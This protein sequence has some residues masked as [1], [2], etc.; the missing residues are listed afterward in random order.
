METQK[1]KLM[2]NFE[3]SEVRHVFDKMR[4]QCCRVI[5]NSI[6]EDLSKMHRDGVVRQSEVVLRDVY[7]GVVMDLRSWVVKSQHNDTVTLRVT[8]PNTWWDHPKHD[9]LN[10]EHPVLKYV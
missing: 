9:L 3:G 8:V 10:D 2:S 4:I 1:N 5:P 6:L 7:C